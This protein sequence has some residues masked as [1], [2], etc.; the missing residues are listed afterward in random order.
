MEITRE[1]F[2]NAIKKRPFYLRN[3]SICN[4]ALS[5]CFEGTQLCYDAGCDCATYN[6]CHPIEEERLDFYLN[7]DHGHLERIKKFIEETENNNV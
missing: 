1:R 6:D 4:Y 3:C 2:I 7:P 5:F